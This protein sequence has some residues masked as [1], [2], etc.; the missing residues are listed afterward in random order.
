[1]VSVVCA[2]KLLENLGS[3]E[4]DRQL[5]RIGIDKITKERAK[6]WTESIMMKEISLSFS[7]TDICHVLYSSFW[8]SSELETN[9]SGPQGDRLFLHVPNDGGKNQNRQAMEKQWWQ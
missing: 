7:F 4:R 9:N 5:N 2:E 8:C 6:L 1:M 3:P